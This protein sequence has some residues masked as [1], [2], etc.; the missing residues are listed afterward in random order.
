[1]S[2]PAPLPELAMRERFPLAMSAASGLVVRDGVA[3]VV[4][5]DGVRLQ[6]YRL[7]GVRLTDLPAGDG[8]PEAP[9][10]K[11]IKPDFEALLDL[12]DG[13]LL[14]LG[15]GSR[16]N[17]ERGMLF[18]P[19]SGR[20]EPLDLAALYRRVRAELGELDVEGAVS[21]GGQLV[22]AHRGVGPQPANALV[23]L[24]GSAL[25]AGEPT[26]CASAYRASVPLALPELDGVPLSLTDLAVHPT[27]GLHFLAAAE[28]TDD[29]YC[30]GP[31]AGSAIGRLDAALRVAWIAR[32]RPDRKTEGLAWWADDGGRG[33]WLAVSDADDP[34]QSTSLFEVAPDAPA[35]R[36]ARALR[37]R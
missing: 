23:L 6:R 8:A 13:R 34:R 24:D 26:F 21:F 15:S 17:R 32:L 31:C 12:P 10:A 11:P 1:M 9:I 16:P 37:A 22:L 18:D 20:A 35:I 36:G 14:A 5:D 2:H 25:A 19:G 7:D 30:D 3:Y 33:R 29:A 28:A 4:A 27:A